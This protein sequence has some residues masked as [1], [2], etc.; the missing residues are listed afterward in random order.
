MIMELSDMLGLA[1]KV[2][3]DWHVIFV[4]LAFL[5]VFAILRYVGLVY[6]KRPKTKARHSPSGPAVAKSEGGAAPARELVGD[7]DSDLI[8]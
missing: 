6:H 8:E 5:L 1:F 3:A 7:S 2:I 4:T